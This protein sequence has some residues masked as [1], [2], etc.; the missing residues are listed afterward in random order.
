MRSAQKV[1]TTGLDIPEEELK[2][3]PEKFKQV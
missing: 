2:R 1:Y 3:H